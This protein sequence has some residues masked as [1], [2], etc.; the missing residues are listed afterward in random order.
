MEI[1]NQIQKAQLTE[2][3]RA[4]VEWMES[5]DLISLA[6]TPTEA[7]AV[8]GHLQLAL[9]HPQNVGASVAIVRDV[10]RRLHRGQ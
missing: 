2:D 1:E 5:G 4:V 7:F 3:E 9:L 6:F 8:I 10:I